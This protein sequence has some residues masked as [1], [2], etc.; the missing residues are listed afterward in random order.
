MSKN[1]ALKVILAIISV[2]HVGLGVIAFFPFEL[3]ASI[4]NSVFGMQFTES[5]QIIYLGHLFGIYTI[6]FGLLI[7]VAAVNPMKY[8]SII[9]VAV[10]LYALRLLNRIMFSSTLTNDFSV[11]TPYLV[12]EV[13]L[14][15]FFGISLYTL[16]PRSDNRVQ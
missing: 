3:V 2:Y 8:R 7:A 11:A 4:V 15:L 10:A 9:N 1:T 12:L 5:G 6:I 14:L 13:V 16:R